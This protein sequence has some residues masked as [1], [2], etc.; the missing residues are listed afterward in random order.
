MS[1]IM[2]CLLIA[3]L[4][5]PFLGCR[6][7]TETT[8]SSDQA[9]FEAPRI[10]GVSADR[11]GGAIDVRISSA[12]ELRVVSIALEA[13]DARGNSMSASIENERGAMLY[14]IIVGLDPNSRKHWLSEMTDAD[15]LHA[16]FSVANGRVFERYNMNGDIISFSYPSIS[17]EAMDRLV[18]RYK[19][20]E[21]LDS[22][23][24]VCEIAEKVRLFDE[25]YGK[26]LGNSLHNNPD[27]FMLVSVLHSRDLAQQLSSDENIGLQITNPLKRTCWAA[28]TCANLKCKLGGLA[29][30]ICD[31]CAGVATA[32]IIAEIACWFLGCDC[33]F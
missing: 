26:H 13:D 22:S 24:V 10:V 18:A 6:S 11:L 17:D 15:T 31:A 33:C 3:V 5:V 23:P 32:C 28:L 8:I 16:S 9:R 25:Y 7:T 21:P 14:K 12:D 30:P 1:R 4:V 19:K 29:N 2:V 20:G 27:G